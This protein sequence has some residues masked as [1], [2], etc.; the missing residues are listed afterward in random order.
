MSPELSIER[1]FRRELDSLSLPD[2]QVW[3]P[4]R[5][6]KP[7][8]IV[9]VAVAAAALV[10]VAAAAGFLREASGT[11][12][13]ST[14]PS[15]GPSMSC[16]PPAFSANRR[17]AMLLPNGIRNPAFGY[18]LTIPGNWRETRMP[19]GT[20]PFVRDRPSA[21]PSLTAPFLLDRHVF[22]ARPAQEWVALTT[23]DMA[24]AWDLDVQVWDRQGRTA[25]EWA[26]FGPC[27]GV[28]SYGTTGCVQTTETIHGTTFVKTTIS[29]LLGPQTTSYYLER[30]DQMLILRYWIDPNIAPPPGVASATLEG[31]V[32]SIGLV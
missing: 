27:N 9:A 28:R 4:V 15:V 20:E 24:P 12:L 32:H 3:V 30:G 2:E 26:T 21:V 10:L 7:S 29:T 13:A 6:T 22:T 1:V 31:I 5:R 17:C 19:A 23:V 16:E 14:P 11:A 18:N 8:A 25:L